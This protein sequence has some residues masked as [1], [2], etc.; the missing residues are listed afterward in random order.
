MQTA[1]P[2]SEE[3]VFHHALQLGATPRYEPPLSLLDPASQ[4]VIQL[5][6]KSPYAAN[7]CPLSGGVEFAGFREN[8]G[9]SIGELIEAMLRSAVRQGATER[10]DG[11][12]SEQQRIDYTVQTAALRGVRGSRLRR[13]VPGLRSGQMELPLQI[14]SNNV[15]VAHRHLGID[16]PEQLHERRQAYPCAYHL[17]GVCVPELVRNDAGADADRSDNIGKVRTKLFDEGLL[18]A[19]TGQEPAVKRE[20]VERT[21]EAQAMDDLTNKGVD[22]DHALGFQ[23]PERNVNRP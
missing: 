19:G 14:G 16:V 22:R 4:S 7:L 11:M 6:E 18:V 1:P 20:W 13:Q 21:E 5:S 9:E 8:F 3:F 2:R 12:L 10:L 23:L 17:T 15:D